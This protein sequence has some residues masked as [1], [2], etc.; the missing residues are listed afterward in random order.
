MQS[1][2][3]IHTQKIRLGLETSQLVLI[4]EVYQIKDLMML[5]MLCCEANLGIKKLNCL[6]S[7][8]EDSQI[9]FATENVFLHVGGVTQERLSNVSIIY[10]F[11]QR[12]DQGK[13]CQ[14]G[15]IL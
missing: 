10:F 2:L 4:L 14:Q 11:K 5:V 12:N 3:H 6:I 1:Y 15:R 7:L 9:D 13:P 8:W